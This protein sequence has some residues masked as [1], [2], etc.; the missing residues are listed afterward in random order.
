MTAIGL[1]AEL[2]ITIFDFIV[3]ALTTS[4]PP[5]YRDLPLESLAVAFAYR[6]LCDQHHLEHLTS[7]TFLGAG[8]DLAARALLS[9]I[10]LQ[11]WQA[12]HLPRLTTLALNDGFSVSALS[13]LLPHIRSLHI[14]PIDV[15]PSAFYEIHPLDRVQAI[16]G[17]VLPKCRNLLRLTVHRLDRVLNLHELPPTLQTLIVKKLTP[18]GSLYMDPDLLKEPVPLEQLSKMTLPTPLNRRHIA[19]VDALKEW[20]KERSIELEWMEEKREIEWVALEGFA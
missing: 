2:L 4:P 9:D 16:Y 3:S 11:D 20:C 12:G 19:W 13:P 7:F 6:N 1:P 5:W 18:L 17:L 15:A 14:T 8:V 10:L